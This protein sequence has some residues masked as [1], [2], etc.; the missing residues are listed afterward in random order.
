MIV[1]SPVLGIMMSDR[2]GSE[3]TVEL[4][5]MAKRL[6]LDRSFVRSE[7]HPIEEHYIVPAGKRDGMAGRDGVLVVTTTAIS[8]LRDSKAKQCADNLSRPLPAS[9]S[10]PPP[11]RRLGRGDKRLRMADA[12]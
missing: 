5:S 7:G 9:I 2:Y 4:R 1:F 3:G 10:T 8:A 12:A 6:R 11:P